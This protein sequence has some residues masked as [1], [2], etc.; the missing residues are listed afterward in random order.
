MPSPGIGSASDKKKGGA[1]V[2]VK[3]TYLAR[4]YLAKGQKRLTISEW[5]KE[6][7]AIFYACV[8]SA[9][10]LRANEKY[11]PLNGNTFSPI[12]FLTCYY[13]HS[14]K[15]KIHPMHSNHRIEEI[16]Q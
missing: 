16:L 11:V 1:P 15:G 4:I 9:A 6:E 7:K 13:F 5:D 8:P 10:S 3:K 14:H 12:T 2:P